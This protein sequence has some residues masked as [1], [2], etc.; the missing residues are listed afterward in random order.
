MSTFFYRRFAVDDFD[1]LMA[2][3]NDIV[4]TLCED[5]AGGDAVDGCCKSL[6]TRS[7]SLTSQSVVVML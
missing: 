3:L 4:D 2:V 5:F 7:D 1:G 6:T